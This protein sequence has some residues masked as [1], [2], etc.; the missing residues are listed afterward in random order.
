M[1]LSYHVIIA[2]D[3]ASVRAIIA[4]VVVG[5]YPGATISAVPNG[6]DA[7]LVYDQRGA[8]LLIT[9]HNMPGMS[10]LSIIEALRVLRQASTPIIMVSANAALEQQAMALGVNV[11][12]AKPFTLAQLTQA[13]TQLLPP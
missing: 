12:L 4:R 1:S 7:L 11:F 6:L 8:D 10:G 9:N 2:D 5:M 3:D 13:L